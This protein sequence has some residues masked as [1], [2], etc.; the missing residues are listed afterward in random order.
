MAL[1]GSELCRKRTLGTHRDIT[2][3]STS[4]PPST[5]YAAYNHMTA[6]TQ[7][8]IYAFHKHE[9]PYEHYETRFRMMMETLRP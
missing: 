6:P 4:C 1:D 7:M 2:S 8:E 5:I 3:A 9:L